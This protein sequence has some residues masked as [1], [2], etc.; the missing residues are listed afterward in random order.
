MNSKL[1]LV[2]SFALCALSFTLITGCAGRKPKKAPLGAAELLPKAN[3]AIADFG[4]EAAK[5]GSEIAAGLKEML[6][7]ALSGN[8]RLSIVER[9]FSD[10][11]IQVQI[12]EF[13]PQTS[14]GK[15]GIGG[16]GGVGSGVLGGLLGNTLNKAYMVLKI[17]IIDTST[18]EVIA[19]TRISG[20]ASDVKGVMMEGAP[21]GLSLAGAVSA[22]AN[23][24]MEKA[25]R[26]CIAEAS[27]YISQAL[28]Q[29]YYKNTSS[30]HLG[31]E[32]LK[33]EKKWEN[34]K[35]EESSTGGQ[36]EPIK[37]ESPT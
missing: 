16:G 8:N 29:S 7:Y 22:Y 10:L 33:G 17:R 34:A 30:D 11:I 3:I 19:S 13:E 6:I 36:K 21:N 5:A 24:P 37:A 4:V 23:T 9:K 25:I 31:S 1:V 32:Q 14:G 20:Q 35:E 27:S 15:S 18:S 28:P 2:L 12:A 26:I